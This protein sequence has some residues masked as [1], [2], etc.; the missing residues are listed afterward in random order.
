MARKYVRLTYTLSL[1]VPEFLQDQGKTLLLDTLIEHAVSGRA[2]DTIQV[3]SLADDE[4]PM[5][6][7]V[8]FT[9]QLPTFPALAA[10]LKEQETA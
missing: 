4:Q 8:E 6:P 10:A 2:S 3:A 1:D 7:D 5:A 9:E